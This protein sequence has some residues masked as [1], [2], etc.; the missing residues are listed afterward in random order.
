[1]RLSASR[2]VQRPR[3]PCTNSRR[4]PKRIVNGT[5][6]PW[7][8]PHMV[9]KVTEGK[10]RCPVQEGAPFCE[11]TGSPRALAAVQS[12]L[13]IRTNSR[14]DHEKRRKWTNG[15]R[16]AFHVAPSV[17]D[18]RAIWS[19]HEDTS[20]AEGRDDYERWRLKTPCPPSTNSQYYGTAVLC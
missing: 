12:T 5:I 20:L 9:P 7:R 18:G 6:G 17:S 19:V 13:R 15:T 8:G 10:D 4:G 3:E 16:K 14:D 2:A 11:R 1:M